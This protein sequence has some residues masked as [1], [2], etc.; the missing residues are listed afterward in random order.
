MSRDMDILVSIIEDDATIREGYQYL[1]GSTD[2]FKVVSSYRSFEEASRRISNDYPDVLLLDVELPGI[3]G[4]DS[5]PKLKKILPDTYIL[6]LTVYEDEEKIFRV[7]SDEPM[8]IDD[9]FVRT[10]LD[11]QTVSRVL[12]L[13][14]C[15]GKVLR[16][17]GN[18][19]VNRNRVGFTY[20]NKTGYC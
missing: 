8:Y 2:G 19:F 17:A 13:W 3:S 9:I 6:I 5:I 12:V 15:Q 4:I 20:G 11:A 14:E 7:L 10:G 1:I 18:Y 16:L